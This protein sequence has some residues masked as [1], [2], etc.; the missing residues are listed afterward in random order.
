MLTE[1]VIILLYFSVV[2]FIAF[3]SRRKDSKSVEDQYLAG[4]SISTF[5]SISSIIATEVSA[6]TFIGIPAFSF[7]VDFRFIFVYVGAIFGR[8]VLAR[9]YLPKLYGKKITIYSTATD[10]RTSGDQTRKILSGV[11]IISKLL[12]VGVRLY[13]G[14]ILVSAFFGLSIYSGIIIVSII[15]SLYTLIGGLKAVIRTDV[16]QAGVFISGGIAAHIIIPQVAGAPWPEM[17]QAGLQNSK[18]FSFDWSYLPIVLTG[19]LGGFL[20]DICTHGVDQ[21]LA[22]RR[23]ANK[24]LKGAQKSIF[25]SSFASI[26]VGL[27]F[28]GIGTLLWSYHQTVPFTLKGD[29]VF[30]DFIIKHFPPSL[31]G[32]MLA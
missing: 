1:I 26:F 15:T 6:L 31:R 30:S 17:M 10:Q 2:F 7:G 20:F 11:Y 21:D 13:S 32:F 19:V 25:L 23:L 3:K 5:E 4:K 12:A 14:S 16:L 9:V 24:S 18:I 8:Y 27:I 28:L 22:Q 29:F